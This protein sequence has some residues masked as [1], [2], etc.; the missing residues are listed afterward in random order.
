M[1]INKNINT[2]NTKSKQNKIFISWSG[3]K[4]KEIAGKLKNFIEE[5]IFKEADINCFVSNVDIVS[6]SDW[7]SRIKGELKKCKLGIVCITKENIY[8]SWIYFETGAMIAQGV[9]VIPLLFNC[10]V[11]TLNNTPLKTKQAVA[12]NNKSYF[13]KMI[14]DIKESMN[15]ISTGNEL[16][17][18]R[19]E[20]AY[21][22]LKEELLPIIKQLTE[23][24]LFNSKY[25]YPPKV[26]T[27]KRNSVYI[28]APMASIC[29][30]EYVKEREGILK[31][32]KGLKE[33]GFEK[34]ISPIIKNKDPESF[35]GN[36]KAIKNN[37]EELK[38]IEYMF[39]IYPKKV[40]SSV[41]VEIGY[42]ISLSKRMVI[43]YKEELPYILDGVGEHISHIKTYQYNKLEDI[44]REISR[45]EMNIFGEVIV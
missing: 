45:T 8:S 38:Q 32:V 2:R 11:S 43:F 21:D 14:K 28:S 10:D 25:I 22:K 3:E 4:S 24:G 36:A 12:F 26:N 31:I 41:L 15:I 9:P 20:K 39:I 23:I 27:V 19:A 29:A 1:E 30:E 17:E 33:I 7:Y 42:G 18:L 13:I 6:G 44:V 34:I 35:E 16:T 37:F 40:P 5:E